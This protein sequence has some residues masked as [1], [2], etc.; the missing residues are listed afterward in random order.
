MAGY[1]RGQQ[2]FNWQG[3]D[4]NNPVDHVQEGYY[5][6]AKN[7]RSYLSGTIQP[8]I[9]LTSLYPVATGQTPAKSFRRLNGVNGGQWVRLTKTGTVLAGERS[10][11]PGSATT[12]VTG[13]STDPIMLVPYRPDESV[14]SWMIFA[15]SNKMGKIRENGT[16]VHQLGL[17]APCEGNAFAM[18]PPQPALDQPAQKEIDYFQY[19]NDA[20]LQFEWTPTTLATLPVLLAGGRVATTTNHVQF[21]VGSSG[22]ASIRLNLDTAQGLA[23]ITPGCTLTIGAETGVMAQEIHRGDFNHVYTIG[24]I[25]YDSGG[26]T[27]ASAI[28]LTNQTTDI[29][30]N[31]LLLLDNGIGSE[32]VRVLSISVGSDGRTSLRCVTTLAHSTASAVFAIA[33]FRAFLGGGHATSGETVSAAAM[34]SNLG[35]SS[36]GTG[37]LT[38]GPFSPVHD[39]SQI[40]SLLPL[41]NEDFMFA[42]MRFDLLTEL[43]SI[44]FMLDVDADAGTQDFTHNYYWYEIRAAD[45]QA[46][47]AGITSLID[48]QPT[49]Q[50]N[51]ILTSGLR[52]RGGLNQDFNNPEGLAGVFDTGPSQTPGAVPTVINPPSS[53]QTGS[54]NG[55]WSTI[56]W[57]I[58]DMNRVGTDASR[59]LR[60][61]A[62]LRIVVTTTGVGSANFYIN[63]WGVCGG[64]SPDSST[65]LTGYTYQVVA[66]SSVTGVQS[67]TSP[68]SRISVDPARQRV[69]VSLT[70]YTA[71]AEADKLDVYRFGGNTLGWHYAGTTNNSATPVFMDDYSDD[72]IGANPPPPDWL[73]PWPEIDAPASGTIKAAVSGVGGAAGTSIQ[74]NAGFNTSWA[75]GTE[76]LINGVSNIVYRVL[77]SSLL[78]TDQPVGFHTAGT[79]VW[80]VPEPILLGRPLPVIAEFAAPS[81]ALFYLGTGSTRNPGRLYYSVGNNA[82]GARIL[83]YVDVTSGSEPLQTIAIYNGQPVVFSSRRAFALA[84]RGTDFVASELPI[85]KGCWNRW[86][87]AVKDLIYFLAEDG[88]YATNTGSTT[89]ITAQRLGPIFPNQIEGTVGVTTNGI[90]APSMTSA[91]ASQMGLSVCGGGRWLYFDYADQFLNRNTL[92]LE[93]GTGAWHYDTYTPGIVFHTDEESPGAL[94]DIKIVAGGADATTAQLYS[95]SGTADAGVAIDCALITP[96]LDVGDPR[97]RKRFGDLSIEINTRGTP[98]S[99]VPAFDNG[100][101]LLGATTL[102][103]TS[104]RTQTQ[105]D[106]N[107]GEGQRAKNISLNISFPA[108]GSQL[109]ILYFWEPTWLDRP[110]GTLKRATDYDNAGNP[111][112]KL[113]AGIYLEADTFGVGRSAILRGD[114]GQVLVTITG[115]NHATKE[116][117]YYP[118]GDRKYAYELSLIGNDALEWDLYGFTPDYEEAPPLTTSPTSWDDLGYAGAKFVQGVVIDADSLNA[119][120][121]MDVQ[122]DE[123]VTQTTIQTGANQG[124]VTMDGRAQKAY[125]F[126]TPFITHL[127]RLAPRSTIRFGAPWKPRW[128]FEPEPELCTHYETQQ[129]THDL[130]GFQQ[131]IDGYVT[132]LSIAT[133]TLAAYVDGSGSPIN[134]VFVS[135]SSNTSGARK[136]LYFRFPP[137]KGK[138]FRYILTSASGFRLYHKD[139]EVRAKSWGDGQFQSF[140]PFG[141]QHRLI[142]ARM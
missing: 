126:D 56:R 26:T 12:L 118:I 44:R 32:Y 37:E 16:D 86:A 85:G 3:L 25:V 100:S 64:Y 23:S 94:H 80:E 120:V 122:V 60:N 128:V 102:P 69:L 125:S 41:R 121:V 123:G 105:I 139:C 99:V 4:L 110:V 83:G 84:E 119:P 63:S 130:T 70:Q 95:V 134:A 35:T 72:V 112:C 45:I 91:N 109:P 53:T 6:Y 138:S 114:G 61:V 24:A 117:L 89:N 77:S 19:A 79:W 137:T 140:N 27:G 81:G 51:A 136:K 93:L 55:Q 57:R 104:T 48:A 15:D 108:A 113:V 116:T 75:Q 73:R 28:Q 10:G 33:S 22:W 66:R 127:V 74:S 111:V 76:I 42:S 132:V 135:E 49:I 124:P 11:A 50:R 5:P 34:Q 97:P 141:D 65:A 129:T 96:S 29:E 98:V 30:I 78:E 62:K 2:R 39:F 1:Q 17:D 90:P 107:G 142:G 103:T 67:G 14:D 58:S 82:D 47:V 54:G 52:G 59:S 9:G 8:R 21:D 7:L 101:V 68:A 131:L 115:I 13:L 133:V 20:A 92:A 88:I 43:V 71:A 38:A 36:G 46:A 31:S 106:F 40:T 87:I 18:T